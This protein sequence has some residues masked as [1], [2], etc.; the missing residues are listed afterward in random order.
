MIA[1]DEDAL[2]CDLAETYGILS[3]RSLPADLVAKLSVGLRADSRIKMKLNKIEVP[4]QTLLLA[5]ILDKL[6]FLAW[7]KTT[8]GSNNINRPFSIVKKILDKE[9]DKETDIVAFTSGEEFDEARKVFI[10]RGR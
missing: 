3:Y 4:V 5:G 2:I 9:T 10:K 7:A 1:L 6:A 8:D